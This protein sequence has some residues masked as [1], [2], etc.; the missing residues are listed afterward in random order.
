VITGQP[1]LLSVS[2]KTRG[3]GYFPD[4]TISKVQ[5]GTSTL[6]P[7]GSAVIVDKG[8][9]TKG[10]GR[11]R[12]TTG[13]YRFTGYQASP[14]APGVYRVRGISMYSSRRCN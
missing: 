12:G 7:D 4:G 2:F 11:R 3:T 13:R 1:T 10:T 9:F 6:Q 5:T 8:H 14:T